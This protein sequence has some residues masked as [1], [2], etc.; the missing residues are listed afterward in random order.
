[1]APTKVPQF[2]GFWNW[3]KRADREMERGPV[4]WHD[5]CQRGLM[6]LLL[7]Y[8]NTVH[9]K[10][11]VFT[12]QSE[13]AL[14]VC[15]AWD[16][17]CWASSPESTIDRSGPKRKENETTPNLLCSELVDEDTEVWETL[18]GSLR[19]KE[20]N[21]RAFSIRVTGAFRFHRLKLLPSAGGKS[22]HRSSRETDVLV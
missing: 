18:K 9:W 6:A 16:K 1:M 4:I 15:H 14:A 19:E 3:S 17:H 13:P 10:S 8:H 22:G 11:N 2:F 7:F 12:G 21:E 5:N 20:L